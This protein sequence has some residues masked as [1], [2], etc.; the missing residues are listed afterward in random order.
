MPRPEPPD[1]PPAFHL[2]SLC[3]NDKTSRRREVSEVA[4]LPPAILSL[5]FETASLS[6][7]AAVGADVYARDPSLAVT[8]IAWAFDD[9]PVHSATHPAA[10]PEAVRAHLLDGGI[11]RAWNAAF[12]SAIL[13]HHYGLALDPRQ[14]SCTMQ[15]AL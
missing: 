1:P 3:L 14:A 10:L 7:L 8:V 12:E 5:D 15:R 13:T 11:F 9:G 4:A 6:D 2:P